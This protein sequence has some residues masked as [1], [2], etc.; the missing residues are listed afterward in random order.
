MKDFGKKRR[1]DEKLAGWRGAKDQ[2]P[3]VDR[4]P[5]KAQ[6]PYFDEID[7]GDLVALPEQHLVSRERSSLKRLFVER[8]HGR[9]PDRPPTN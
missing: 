9:S 4:A 2:R 6:P 7:G 1:F 3:A 8:Q 5:L